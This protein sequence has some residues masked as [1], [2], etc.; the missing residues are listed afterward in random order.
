MIDFI[1]FNFLLKIFLINFGFKD[2][3]RDILH[4]LDII[5]LDEALEY[6]R[7]YFFSG[8]GL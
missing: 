8:Y 7:D 3:F 5:V 1:F 2:A 4:E 6:I